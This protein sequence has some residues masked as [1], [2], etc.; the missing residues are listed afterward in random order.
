MGFLILQ[1]FH[2]VYRGRQRW[3]SAVSR[4]HTFW[5]NLY[6][7]VVNVGTWLTRKYWDSQRTLLQTQ[8]V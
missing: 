5:H 2:F 8:G 7:A 4:V 6:I 1:A 3:K